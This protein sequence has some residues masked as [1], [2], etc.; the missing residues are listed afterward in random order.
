MMLLMTSLVAAVATASAAGAAAAAPQDAAADRPGSYLGELAWPEAE[1]RFAEAAVV[2]LPF[3]AGAKEH[4]PHLPMNADLV[5]AE[6]LLERAVERLPVLVAPAI[7]HGWFPA[8]REFPGTEVADPAIFQAYVHQVALSLVRSGAKRL[9]LLN[10]GIRNATGL[11]ISIVAREITAETGVPTLVVSWD[12]LETDEVA[13]LQQ[14]PVDGHA[15]EVETSIHLYLQPHLVDLDAAVT[16]LGA[17]A[18][19]YPGYRPGGFSR[20]PE[21]PRYTPSGVF[22]DG[23]LG[24]ADFGE[25][26]MAILTEQ[27]LAALEGFAA[28]PLR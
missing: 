21:S 26:V 22:G 3:G 1:R 14:S 12:D 28:E 23:T 5:V 10:T 27:W 13:A 4:G 24:R 8:F 9:V 11:P 25:R 20:D 18:K 16:D 2:V 6:Y 19:D 17:G 7:T 15:G